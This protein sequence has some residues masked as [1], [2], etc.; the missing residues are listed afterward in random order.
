MA[1]LPP[2]VALREAGVDDERALRDEGEAARVAAG[3]AVGRLEDLGVGVVARGRRVAGVDRGQAVGGVARLAAV[4]RRARRGAAAFWRRPA[5]L[6]ELLPVAV[7]PPVL[8]RATPLLVTSAPCVMM[9]MLPELPGGLPVAVWLMTVVDSLPIADALPVEIVAVPFEPFAAVPLFVAGP[10]FDA[11]VWS[12]LRVLSDWLPMAM[13]PPVLATATPTLATTAVWSTTWRLPSV[14]EARGG[15]GLRGAG[16]VADRSRVAGVRRARA[17]GR[18][19]G[20]TAVLRVGSRGAQQGDQRAATDRRGRGCG[21]TVRSW[22]GPSI[23]ARHGRQRGFSSRMVRGA[24]RGRTV[25]RSRMR[26]TYLGLRTRTKHPSV[27]N[28]EGPAGAGPSCVLGTCRRRLRPGCWLRRR[29]PKPSSRSISPMAAWVSSSAPVRGRPPG[30]PGVSGVVVGRGVTSPSSQQV[31]SPIWAVPS[32]SLVASPSLLTRPAPSAAWSRTAR[33][34]ESLPMP[35]LRP[36]LARPT[37]DV[38]GAADDGSTRRSRQSTEAAW[39]KSVVDW[40]PV[41]EALPEADVARAGRA[42]GRRCRR[43]GRSAGRRPAG[44]GGRR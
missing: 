22:R 36:E 17:V 33:L 35:R 8:A 21:R 25:G 10:R 2:V 34:V 44:R 42:V 15:L 14:P 38:G 27:E 26:R 3:G 11:A 29:R 19:A 43:C 18:G 23:V 6:V 37:T 28:D 31:G 13:L 4:G 5:L 41:P 30:S 24:T 40:L 32:E 12:A 1:V 16:P 7:L 9:R 20:G 39:T